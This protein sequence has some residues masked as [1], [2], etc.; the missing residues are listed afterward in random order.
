MNVIVGRLQVGASSTGMPG[1]RGEIY[2]QRG[3]LN[4]RPGAGR[5]SSRHA[6]HSRRQIKDLTGVFQVA[7]G[8]H[9]LDRRPRSSTPTASGWPRQPSAML[10]TVRRADLLQPGGRRGGHAAHPRVRLLRACGRSRRAL[11][12][13]D[14]MWAARAS[15]LRHRGGSNLTNSCR[16]TR[17]GPDSSTATASPP[18]RAR[19]Q[20]AHRAADRAA[21][22]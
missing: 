11:Q 20:L 18:S 8:H 5:I 1:R 13:T 12:T 21:G 22:F 2:A 9:L 16:S 3:T 6:R 14:G 7:D 17:G 19:Q 4:A 15:G 10:A